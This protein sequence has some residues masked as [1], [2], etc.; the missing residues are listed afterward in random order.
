MNHGVGGS[1]AVVLAVAMSLTTAAAQQPATPVLRA[2]V[3]QVVVDV[4]VTDADGSPVPGL[5]AADFEI[6]E[7]GK[8]QP[9]ATFSEVSLPLVRRAEGA[10][11]PSPGDV[12]SN[13]RAAEARVYILLLDDVNVRIEFT[14]VVQ[15]AAR[16]FVQRYVQPGDLV[17][18]LTTTGLG[19]TRQEPTEDL[20]LVDAT[21]GRFAGHGTDAVSS[22]SQSRAARAAQ[23]RNAD[24]MT[25][26]RTST[27]LIDDGTVDD[28]DDASDEGRERARL[29]LRTLENIADSVAAVAGRRKSVLLFS[30]GPLLP[31]RDTEMRDAESRMLAAAARANVS[32]YAIDPKGLDHPTAFDGRGFE[33][34]PGSLDPMA[35][36]RS[37]DLNM[38][39]NNIMVQR[40]IMAAATLRGLSDGTGGVATI[41]KTNIATAFERVA[42][43]SSHYYLLGYAPP[44]FK[45]EGRFRSIDVRVK[46][47]GLTVSARKGYVEPDDKALRKATGKGTAASGAL[48]E[49]IRRPVPVSGLSLSAQAILLPGGRN[50]VRVVVDVAPRALLAGAAAKDDA[51][52]DLVIVPVA[53]GGQV[54]PSVE[55]HVTLAVSAADA[56][57]IHERGLRLVQPLTLAPGRYQLRIAARETV[58]GAAGSVI[59]EVDVPKPDA[60]LGL[61]SLVLSSRQA[62]RVPSGGS[63]DAALEAA[64]GGRPPTTSRTFQAD[65]VMSVY[66]EGID[67]GATSLRAVTLTTVVRDARGRELVRTAHLN[68]NANVKPGRS[69]AYVVDLPLAS[70][71]PG[72]YTLRVEAQADGAAD[73]VARETPFEVRIAS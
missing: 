58:A 64:L 72:H 63:R 57:T 14:P 46:K 47:P 55:A 1:R 53:S 35:V 45:R 2:S 68:A 27:T 6:F 31:F 69:F 7:R 71:Q 56:G 26:R 43:D 19:V 59:C 61:S 38:G 15:Q 66:A 11:P 39:L 22:A 10:V 32:I 51:A 24:P 13:A 49:L 8:A 21:I 36:Q 37:R 28:K 40:R 9:V 18:V 54:L 44:D 67:A 29:T 41:D 5:T 25:T 73:V 50:N 70:L 4:V 60:G 33:A 16:L 30:E 17:A 42:A 34:V 52:L 62:G 23:T 65:D 48:A 12:R 3:D 20:A